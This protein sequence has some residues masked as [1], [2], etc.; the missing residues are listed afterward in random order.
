MKIHSVTYS[1]S[2]ASLEKC[3]E[4]LKV[5]YAFIGRSNVGKSSLINMLLNR[6]ELAYTS[7][8]PGRTQTLNYYFVNDDFY[9][10]DMPG[11]GYAKRSV[12]QRKEWQNLLHSFFSQR[13]NV[14]CVFLLI[15][16]RITPQQSDIEMAQMLGKYE[17][18]FAFMFT[19]TDQVKKG[20]LTNRISEFK[21]ELQKSFAF[22]PQSFV[23]SAKTGHGKDEILAFI[24]EV[25]ETVKKGE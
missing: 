18:P 19:K 17:V 6:K 4:P 20:R 14:E 21:K 11:Y 15:D 3:P 5:E 8:H 2:F 25:N 16:S 13:L 9:L 10:V 1:G 23:T 22:L 12:K 24:Q 7:K